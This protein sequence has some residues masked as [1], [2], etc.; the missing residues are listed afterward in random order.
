MTK[1]NPLFNDDRYA[2]LVGNAATMNNPPRI[3]IGRRQNN[4]DFED[5]GIGGL[6]DMYEYHLYDDRLEFCYCSP[7]DRFHNSVLLGYSFT[8]DAQIVDREKWDKYVE[9]NPEDYKEDGEDHPWRAIED[10]LRSS[11]GDQDDLPV[12]NHRKVLVVWD[13]KDGSSGIPE[14]YN[15]THQW[16]FLKQ[17]SENEETLAESLSDFLETFIDDLHANG[18]ILEFDELKKGAW[19]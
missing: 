13:F 11:C 18:D 16:G 10:Q 7:F 9:D 12:S 6:G 19:D 2:A 5:M 3:V 4:H 17:A 14:L 15:G 1:I 8:G